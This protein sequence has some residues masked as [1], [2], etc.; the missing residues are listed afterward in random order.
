MTMTI[1]GDIVKE[2]LIF[3]VD[4]ANVKSHVTGSSV[5]TDMIGKVEMGAYTQPLD[6][7]VSHVNFPVYSTDNFGCFM[8]DPN[9]EHGLMA[10][11]SY[12]FPDDEITMEAWW[13][14]DAA[15][16][17]GTNPRVVELWKNLTNNNADCYDGHA[18]NIEPD[19][20]LR[21]WV[22]EGP[23]NGAT[24]RL[25]THDSVS[26]IF[27]TVG[28]WYHIVSTFDGTNFEMYVNYSEY[29]YSNSSYPGGVRDTD[30]IQ[31]GN[32][33]NWYTSGDNVISGSIA[34]VRVYNKCLT[35]EQVKEQF[36][37]Q[38]ARFGV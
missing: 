10:T 24:N 32:I 9:S 4:A 3:A 33:G 15:D 37:Q 8:F 17:V 28:K 18:I 19:R 13:R 21:S 11:G 2:G 29:R 38:R 6:P 23:N 20:S 1:G 36:N 31:I 30:R 12:S 5:W 22:N 26:V 25:F 34:I 27:D 14:Y 7:G 16:Y 35:D